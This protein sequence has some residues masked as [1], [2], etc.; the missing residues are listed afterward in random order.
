MKKVIAL[1]MMVAVVSVGSVVG[2]A[3][4][5]RDDGGTVGT[6]EHGSIWPD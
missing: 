5:V 2:A 4:P 3:K 6:Q 1:L